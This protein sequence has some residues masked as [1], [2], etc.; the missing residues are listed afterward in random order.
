MAEKVVVGMSGGVDSSVAAYLLQLQGYDVVGV[1]MQ[2]W[3][4]DVPLQSGRDDRCCSAEAA[5]D[6]RRVCLRLG[7]PY[8]VVNYRELFKERVIEP[9]VQE[10]LNARTP[11]PCLVCNRY[12]KWESLTK[13]ACELGAKYVATGHYARPV[14]LAGGRYTVRNAVTAAKDQ[15]YALCRL[16]QE[17]LACTLMPLGDYYKEDVRRIAKEAGIPVADKPDSEDVCFIHDGDYAGFVDRNAGR[18]LPPPG[19]FV[20]KDG[21]DLGPHKG[22]THYTVGQRKGLG[23]SMGHSVFVTK[24]DAATGEVQIGEADDCMRDTLVCRD[25]NFMAISPGE[26]PVG[27]TMGAVPATHADTGT[28]PAI[29]EDLMGGTIPDPASGG[30]AAQQGRR[31]TGRI[32]YS[33]GAVPCT[34][35]RTG[36]DEIT[37][38]FCKKVRAITPGQ[39]AVFY[40]DDHIL[41]SGTIAAG[42]NSEE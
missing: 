11:N 28:A 2:A 22:I 12:V 8:Y 26:L 37:A 40:E 25:L 33:A 1:T 7:I 38:R 31:I 24:I 14:R 30:T 34:I 35:R 21:T 13:K 42:L 17:Q 6:A 5:D 10:Y 9:F 36:T 41:L 20:Y 16:T 27:A 39:A 18:R 19:R 4:P 32:R 3:D 29:P 15:T 23:L